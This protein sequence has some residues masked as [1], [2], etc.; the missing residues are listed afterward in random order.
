MSSFSKILVPL[1]FSEH[2]DR[3]VA[4]AAELSGRY[5]APLTL[6]HV[7]ELVPYALP[8][9]PALYA[10]PQP[11]LIPDFHPQLEQLR[12]RAL[13][14]G[15]ADVRSVVREGFAAAQ[16][17]ELARDEHFDLIVMGTHGRKGLSHLFMGS[18]AEKVVRTAPCPVL[19]VRL[20]EAA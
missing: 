20:A 2:S 16:I 12:A 11:P 10:P 17:T 3:A 8:E 6:L 9:S 7:Y 13:A 1:D 14:A 18:V 19:T 5:A 15:A 4:L